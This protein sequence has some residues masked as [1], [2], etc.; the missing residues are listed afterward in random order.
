LFSEMA[1]GIERKRETHKYQ[2]IVTLIR[3]EGR[4]IAR[5]LI[6]SYEGRKIARALIYSCSAQ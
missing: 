5:A 3:Y 2:S 1:S 4:R 6:Y